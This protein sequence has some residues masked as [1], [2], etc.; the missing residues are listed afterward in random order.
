MN[1]H[2]EADEEKKE[3]GDTIGVSFVVLIMESGIG[4]TA[5]ISFSFSTFKHST[6]REDW[7]AF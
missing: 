2:A 6:T 7:S 4:L 3:D 5:D 1:T